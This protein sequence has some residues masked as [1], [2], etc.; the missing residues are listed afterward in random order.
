MFEADALQHC[1][2]AVAAGQFA[3]SLLRR[4]AARTHDVCRAEI[5]GK[6]NAVGMPAKYNDLFSTES[7]CGNDAAQSHSSNADNS[8]ALSWCNSRD[9]CGVMSGAH[10]VRQRE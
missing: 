1:V 4:G 9:D 5:P 6:C 2:V 10:H 3:A 7:L 8:H